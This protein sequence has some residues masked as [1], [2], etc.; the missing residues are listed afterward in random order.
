MAIEN[1]SWLCISDS[2]WKDFYLYINAS[3]HIYCMYSTCIYIKQYLIIK[4]ICENWLISGRHVRWN[5]II[6]E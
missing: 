3:L 5:K 6:L 1:N 4:A 2:R